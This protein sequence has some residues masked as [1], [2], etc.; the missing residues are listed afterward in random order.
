MASGN[1]S[2][3]LQGSL[4]D[5]VD[6]QLSTPHRS[7][8]NAVDTTTGAITEKAILDL[9]AFL[10]Y[11]EKEFP[12]AKSA[13]AVRSDVPVSLIFSESGAT[14][15]IEVWRVFTDEKGVKRVKGFTSLSFTAGT[16]LRA[17]AYWTEEQY[18]AG[19]GATELRFVVTA[20]SAGSVSIRA[21]S[22]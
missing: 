11:G 16:A 7:A 12:D 3:A 14:A 8:I 9:P 13:E 5:R 17:G 1:T 15:T 21:G 2:S 6:R 4:A 20:L 22:V 19:S 10:L 18:V